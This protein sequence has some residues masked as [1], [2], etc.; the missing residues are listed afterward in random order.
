MAFRDLVRC[1][2][3]AVEEGV[4]GECE[5]WR[6]GEHLRSRESQNTKNVREKNGGQQ[7]EGC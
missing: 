3:V 4:E 5:G 7:Q 6:E 1:S 2:E